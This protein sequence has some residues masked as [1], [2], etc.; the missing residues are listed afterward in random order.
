MH[1][2]CGRYGHSKDMCREGVMDDVVEN[3]AN[4]NAT[5]AEVGNPLGGGLLCLPITKRKEEYHAVGKYAMRMGE[6]I[7]GK[8]EIKGE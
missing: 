6:K 8:E 5:A 4:T 7:W 3:E 2:K 1:P